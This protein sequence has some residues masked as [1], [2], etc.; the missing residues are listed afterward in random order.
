MFAA[1]ANAGVSLGSYV[2]EVPSWV[3]KPVAIQQPEPY[4]GE[5][6]KSLDEYISKVGIKEE[7]KIPG[8]TRFMDDMVDRPMQLIVRGGKQKDV[9]VTKDTRGQDIFTPSF[10]LKSDRL[11]LKLVDG[12]LRVTT[13]NGVT[14]IPLPEG[15][16]IFLN[17]LR[18]Q[19]L[20]E[21]KN[22][23]R[24]NE[25]DLNSDERGLIRRLARKN[26]I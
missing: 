25:F 7:K 11:E 14:M 22:N 2:E 9:S 8:A 18:L 21:L 16:D 12:V 23:V 26:E 5:S 3:G 19:T 17:N 20:S 6:T 4:T 13:D 10:S 15:D 1:M 24:L